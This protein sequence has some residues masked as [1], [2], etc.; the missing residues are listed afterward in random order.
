M[1][2]MVQGIAPVIAAT[3]LIPVNFFWKYALNSLIIK[4]LYFDN[5]YDETKDA[6]ENNTKLPLKFIQP[7]DYNEPGDKLPSFMETLKQARSMAKNI[8]S[9]TSDFTSIK[10]AKNIVSLVQNV[11]DGSQGILETRNDVKDFVEEHSTKTITSNFNE[12][13]PSDYKNVANKTE[14]K[15][16]KL[17]SI[18]KIK[19]LKELL[20]MGAITKEE[21]ELKKKTLLK[22]L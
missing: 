3:I 9:V 13:P 4:R 17:E 8:Q 2:S 22:D 10:D 21:F 18:E 15:N 14:N 6:L 20:D 12:T 5:F 1:L 11:K 7:P 19:Q 16:D